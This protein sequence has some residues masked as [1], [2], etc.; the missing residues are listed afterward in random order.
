MPHTI[1]GVRLWVTPFIIVKVNLGYWKEFQASRYECPKWL[2]QIK[3]ACT[4]DSYLMRNLSL[5]LVPCYARAGH[6]CLPGSSSLSPTYNLWSV[7]SLSSLPTNLTIPD[8]I[9]LVLQLPEEKFEQKKN[10]QNWTYSKSCNF[11][12][13]CWSSDLTVASK[14]QC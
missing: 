11:A 10:C 3:I 7:F 8:R 12:F 6:I 4:V 1:D 9:S 13:K 5:R 2:Y 14:I